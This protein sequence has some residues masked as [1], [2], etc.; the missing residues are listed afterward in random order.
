MNTVVI[1]DH[2]SKNIEG[3][4]RMLSS[5]KG[6][7]ECKFFQIPEEALE[8]V[9]KYPTAVLISEL[10]IPVMS[11]KEVFDMVEMFS[12]LTV[13]IAMT[14]VEDVNR[15]LE[16]FNRTRLFRLIVKPFFLAEDIINP[17]QEALKY[18]EAAQKEEYQRKRMTT[19][20]ERLN[21]IMQKLSL[22]MEEKKRKHEGI[23]HV[24]VGVIKGNL[25]SEVKGLDAAESGYAAA[26]C[27][28]L[29]QEFMRC[30]MYEEHDY[31]FHIKRLQKLFHRPEEGCIFQIQNKTKRPV[32]RELMPQIAYGIFLGGYLCQQMLTYYRTLM[33]IET[34]GSDY[35][36]RMFCQFSGKGAIYRIS[37]EKTRQAIIDIIEEIAKSL[38]T[39]MVRGSREKEFALKLYFRREDGLSE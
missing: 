15:T 24:A 22:K 8:Y 5:V 14:Q 7:F 27:E 37:D 35:V 18:Y 13:R 10:D 9:K 11:G 30:Y 32:P 6:D 38:A 36:L 4:K 26:A 19:E 17:I 16:I 28:E 21:Q 39:S 25:N 29:L 31:Q 2:D 20:L 1:L 33:L 34:E 12:P 23:Y 3:C